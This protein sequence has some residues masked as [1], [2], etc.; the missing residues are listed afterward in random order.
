MILTA[1]NLRLD[2]IFCSVFLIWVVSDICKASDS[3]VTNQSA[4]LE[5]ESRYPVLTNAEQVH[6][7][8]RKEAAGGQR[9][10][11]RGVITCVLPEFQAA[12]VQDFTGG[13][14]FDLWNTSLAGPL[15][16]GELVEVEGNTD[17]GEFAPRVHAVRIT[18]LGSGE[19]PPPVHPYWDQLINGSL[20]TRFVE[21]QGIV[22]SVNTN[23]VI[24]LTHGGKINVVF[25]G[26]NGVTNT[27]ALKQYKDALVRLRGCL[28][29]S[30][31]SATHQVNVGEVRMFNPSVMVDEPAPVD[32][33]AVKSKRAMDL[34]LFDPHASALERVKVF[35]QIVNER[36]GSCRFSEP[37]GAGASFTGGPRAKNRCGPIARCPPA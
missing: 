7:L 13:I 11:I 14:Y 24:L 33:F 22:T 8:T 21:I 10:L 17:P 34:L 20:D 6:W 19:L 26:K 1:L 2:A 30:W 5:V 16:V 37:G 15:P 36:G 27:F 29:A 23:G 35:G 3:A 25:F 32:V 28:F 12:V 9:V 31:D 4:P 18:Q